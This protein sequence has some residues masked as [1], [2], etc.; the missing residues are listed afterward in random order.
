MPASNHQELLRKGAKRQY[1][2]LVNNEEPLT[3]TSSNDSEEEYSTANN[4]KRKPKI[5][6]LNK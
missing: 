3:H 1:K 5:P 6:A 2:D 4:G